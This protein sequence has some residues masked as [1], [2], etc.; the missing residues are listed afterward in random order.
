LPSTRNSTLAIPLASLAVA[1][2]ETAPGPTVAPL[3]GAVSAT[4]GG[5]LSAGASIV[6]VCA[7]ERPKLPL[8]S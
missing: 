4:V 5:V 1:V 3:A 7:A 8:S 2:S 6:T